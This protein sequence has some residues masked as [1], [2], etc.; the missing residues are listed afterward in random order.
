MPMTELDIIAKG[1]PLLNVVMVGLQL[2]AVIAMLT[3]GNFV[4]V[5]NGL[6]WVW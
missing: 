4:M 2:P 5:R 6:L 3:F 1:T